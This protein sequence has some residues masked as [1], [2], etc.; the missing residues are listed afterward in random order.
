M[1]F[2]VIKCLNG[3]KI[4]IKNTVF[5]ATKSTYLNWDLAR[6]L[7]NKYQPNLPIGIFVDPVKI[8]NEIFHSRA[9]EESNL[10]NKS[11]NLILTVM[12]WFRYGRFLPCFYL[13]SSLLK[14]ERT[15]IALAMIAASI[16]REMLSKCDVNSVKRKN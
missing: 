9:L 1:S 4:F 11:M 2:K 7:W 14:T 15:S 12:D 6:Y 13:F 5:T 10:V 8:G 16:T 3:L